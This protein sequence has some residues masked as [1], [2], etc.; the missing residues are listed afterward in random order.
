MAGGN[1]SFYASGST[2]GGTLTG[3]TFGNWGTPEPTFGAGTF[4]FTP[5]PEAAGFAV[6]GVALLGIV[7]IGRCY[8][9]RRKLAV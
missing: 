7:Y 5:V 6:A 8:T 1:Y 3:L 4:E 9:Q 2:L